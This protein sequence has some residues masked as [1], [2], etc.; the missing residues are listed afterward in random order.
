LNG[1]VQR[2]LE[3]GRQDLSIVSNLGKSYGRLLGPSL[4][5]CS[6][7]VTF[8]FQACAVLPSPLLDTATTSTSDV[9]PR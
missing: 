7:L 1:V 8:L 3:S 4:I 2:D 9:M 6:L 5:R